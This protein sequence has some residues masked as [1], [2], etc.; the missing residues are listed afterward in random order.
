MR[1]VVEGI[2]YVCSSLLCFAGFGCAGPLY[3]ISLLKA[4]LLGLESHV[5]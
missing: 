4:K 2:D 1:G 3:V 5:V